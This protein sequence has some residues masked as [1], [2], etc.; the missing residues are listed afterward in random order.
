MPAL[1]LSQRVLGNL[2]NDATKFEQVACLLWVV[3]CMPA[4]LEYLRKEVAIDR[5]TQVNGDVLGRLYK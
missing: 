1:F 2:G 5:S 3:G 4:F